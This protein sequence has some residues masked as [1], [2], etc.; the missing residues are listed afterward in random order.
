MVAKGKRMRRAHL[1]ITRPGLSRSR[2]PCGKGSRLMKKINGRVEP[3]E[4]QLD[5]L[6][7]TLANR[8][9]GV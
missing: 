6:R 9:I 8:R 1:G 4:T 7:R 3:R 5:K 2:L